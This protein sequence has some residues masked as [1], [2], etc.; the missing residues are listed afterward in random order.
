TLHH[1]LNDVKEAFFAIAAK[2]DK[3]RKAREVWEKIEKGLEERKLLTSKNLKK[4]VSMLVVVWHDP[5]IVAGGWSYISDIMEAVGIRNT[6]GSKRFSFPV[7][8]KE[9]L[10]SFNPDV[11]FLV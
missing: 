9:E 2:I 7:M 6:A 11:I 1:R 5:L 10:L 4:P 8:S 3:T